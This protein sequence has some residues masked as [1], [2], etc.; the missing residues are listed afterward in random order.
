M[1]ILMCWYKKPS[2]IQ[3]TQ[4]Y[5]QGPRAIITPMA[6]PAVSGSQ[7]AFT[8]TEKPSPHIHPTQARQSGE[9]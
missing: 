2:L 1:T 6:V 3:K 9:R 5:I 7:W 8:R 4:H